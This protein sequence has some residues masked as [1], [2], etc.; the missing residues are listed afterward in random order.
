M[1]SLSFDWGKSESSCKS[2]QPL[3]PAE[4]KRRWRKEQ[5]I[6]QQKLRPHINSSWRRN[7]LECLWC[8][9]IKKRSRGITAQ[10]NLRWF[11]LRQEPIGGASS[12]VYHAI[13]Q[14]ES[15]ASEKA[16]QAPKRLK[17]IDARPESV[18]SWDG[19]SCFSVAVVGRRDRILLA[20]KLGVE[21]DVLL[22]RI[23]SILAPPPKPRA[24]PMPEENT[25]PSDE[26]RM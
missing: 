2:D 4:V 20:M 12:S 15:A 22:S 24:H 26:E 11:E 10:W 21:V 5:V 16:K 25:T 8:G 6:N 7:Q 18:R 14:Y 3:P 23:R 9:W 17:I 13:L 1:P 19:W